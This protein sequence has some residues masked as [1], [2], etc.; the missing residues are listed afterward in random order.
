[1]ANMVSRN[2]CSRH[3]KVFKENIWRNTIFQGVEESS[4]IASVSISYA[5]K[6]SFK[7]TFFKT[8]PEFICDRNQSLSKIS[9]EKEE[10]DCSSRND[11][12]HHCQATP[13][14]DDEQHK[15]EASKEEKSESGYDTDELQ[16]KPDRGRNNM[17][18]SVD[19]IVADKLISRFV[20]EFIDTNKIAFVW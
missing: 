4:E 1:M 9:E 3:L 12:H 2:T 5:Q 16:N 18:L 19:D 11:K 7:K 8:R 17:Q 10:S 6:K 20:P 13:A 15:S 14:C